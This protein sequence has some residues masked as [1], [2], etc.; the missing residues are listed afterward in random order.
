MTL[1]QHTANLTEGGTRTLRATTVPEDAVVEWASS[2]DAVATVDGGVVTALAEG[3]ATVTA[4]ITVDGETY[5]DSCT[6]N[7]TAA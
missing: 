7:V 4:T 3:T 1:N 5:D 6:V 2:D